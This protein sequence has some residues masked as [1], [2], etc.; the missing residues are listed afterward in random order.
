MLAVQVA[1][2]PGV[3]TIVEFVELQN[4]DVLVVGYQGSLGAV[5]L[6]YWTHGRSTC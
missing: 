6:P 3:P 4:F 1:A 2:G 5:Q